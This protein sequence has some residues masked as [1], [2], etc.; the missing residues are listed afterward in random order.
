MQTKSLFPDNINSADTSLLENM[1]AI[2]QKARHLY[3]EAFYLRL[4]MQKNIKSC[5]STHHYQVGYDNS[6]IL[7]VA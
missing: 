5:V 1:R 6:V 2:S 7:E 3:V 4:D